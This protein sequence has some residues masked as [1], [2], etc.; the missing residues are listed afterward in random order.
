LF[1]EKN[2]S[3]HL[4]RSCVRCDRAHCFRLILKFAQA[5][6]IGSGCGGAPIGQ[7]LY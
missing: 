7:R 5:L 3:C 6:A 2:S 4:A 1:E